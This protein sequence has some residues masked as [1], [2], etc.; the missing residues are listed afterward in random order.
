METRNHWQVK[1]G[2][3]KTRIYSIWRNMRQRCNNPNASKYHLYGGKGIQVCSEWQT[4]FMNFYEWAMDNGYSDELTLDRINGNK[5]Y[6]PKN[7]RWATY[8]QQ[9]NNTTQ[10]HLLTFKGET[11]SIHEWAE[12]VGLSK[13]CL[14]ER[15]RRG[16]TTERALTTPTVRIKNFGNF[17]KERKKV[18]NV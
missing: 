14:S 4:D 18:K 8:K 10:N 13:K 5:D 2:M 1:H 11:H 9:N 12:I 3:Y 17:I 6:C 15:I 16:W 7:C